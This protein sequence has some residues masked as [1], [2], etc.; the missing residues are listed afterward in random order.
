MPRHH[1][2]TKQ[3]EYEIKIQAA[4]RWD[5]LPQLNALNMYVNMI[6]VYSGSITDVAFI[7]Q[8]GSIFNKSKTH[9]THPRLTLKLLASRLLFPHRKS[10]L[11][12]LFYS[13]KVSWFAS[14]FGKTSGWASEQ[15]EPS[16]FNFF[17]AIITKR[18]PAASAGRETTALLHTAKN[19]TDATYASWV[20]DQREEENVWSV[21]TAVSCLRDLTSWVEEQRDQTASVQNEGLPQYTQ[22]KQL[23]NSITPIH[24]Q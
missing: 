24:V 7:I 16:C 1:F 19:R 20:D 10:A 2:L 22:N 17:M 23:L 8:T 13:K 5:Q 9:P 18:A 3:V 4:P 14:L 11:Y 15:T 12:F 21:P 6:F